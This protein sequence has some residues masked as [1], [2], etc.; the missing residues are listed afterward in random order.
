MPFLTISATTVSGAILIF[1]TPS[2]HRTLII[3]IKA[4]FSSGVGPNALSGT[5]VSIGAGG[6]AFFKEEIQPL[7]V[8][9]EVGCLQVFRESYEAEEYFEEGEGGLHVGHPLWWA[10]GCEAVRG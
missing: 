3:R 10:S 4:D 7:I 6:F 2:L 5:L 9:R 1:L 8:C